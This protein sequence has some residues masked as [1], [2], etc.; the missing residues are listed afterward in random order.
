MTSSPVDAV[1]AG[2]AQREAPL[3]VAQRDRE[4]VDLELRDVGQAVGRL[5]GGRE[6]EAA[7]DARVEGAQLV[8]A[9]RV[10][11]AEHRAL[12]AD[13]GEATARRR[14]AH[15][16]GR[17]VGGDQRRERGLERDELPEQ[18][19]V[20]GVGELRRVLLVVEAVRALDLLDELGVAGLGGLGLERGGGVD[21]R[22]VDG[23]RS[24]SSPPRIRSRGGAGTT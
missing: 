4:A 8:V 1:A 24:R 6:A 9:E 3:L 16:L 23:Q 13:L 14:A 20:L 19:V 5:G 10:R 11:Q 2:G 22:G 7:P 17:R 12:V 18:L 15:L 21:E